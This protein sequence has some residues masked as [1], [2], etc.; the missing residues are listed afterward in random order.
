M[1]FKKYIKNED[2]LLTE[3]EMRNNTLEYVDS[4]IPR[5]KVGINETIIGLLNE[6]FS[7]YDENTLKDEE[8]KST[9]KEIISTDKRIDTAAKNFNNAVSDYN[10]KINSF[11]S[12]IIS[13]FRGFKRVDEFTVSVK[14]N[15]ILETEW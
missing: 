7:K 10:S 12:S 5:E 9:I 14:L 4:F 3:L 6:L 2:T 13:F 8:L 1:N 11:P 15:N